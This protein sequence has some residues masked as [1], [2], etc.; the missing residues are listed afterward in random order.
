MSRYK[1]R[2]SK[3]AI[4]RDFPHHVDFVTPPNGFGN[5]LNQMYEWLTAHGTQC[6]HG[7]GWREEC[8]NIKARWIVRWCFKDATAAKEFAAEFSEFLRL[9]E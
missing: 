8:R 1:G 6:Q 9:P 5:R 4:E 2:A 7:R 3:E